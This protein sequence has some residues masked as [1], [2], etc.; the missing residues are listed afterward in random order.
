MIGMIKEEYKYSAET[1][2]IIGC[3][4][5]VHNVLGNGFQEAIYQR[6]LGIEL[7]KAGLAFVR[8]V[9]MPI[10]YEGV[11]VGTRRA[12]FLVEGKILVE[13]KA[14]HILEGVHLAQAL[15]YLEAYHLD[16]GLLINFGSKQLEFKRLTNEHKRARKQS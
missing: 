16:V 4:M 12:D 9:E 13:L 11:E 3:A 6:C 15:N 5:K 14:L 10:H 8:E 7:Q 1:E 2:K